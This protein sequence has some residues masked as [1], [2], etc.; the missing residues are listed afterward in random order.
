MEKTK[1]NY[2]ITIGMFT[3][4]TVK[5]GIKGVIELIE[6]TDNAFS[7]FG[8]DIVKKTKKTKK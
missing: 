2:K 6:A 1:T 5:N 4:F 7:E 8:I 3:P